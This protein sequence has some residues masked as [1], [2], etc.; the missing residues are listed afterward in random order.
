MSFNFLIRGIF[1]I[2]LTFSSLSASFVLEN[3]GFLPL[4]SVD[5]INEMAN[6]LKVKTNI[7]V[8]LIAK[9]TINNQNIKD[10]ELE[11]VKTLNKPFVLLTFAHKE[12]K[13]DIVSSKELSDK[14]DKDEILDNYIIPILISKG[15]IPSKY[16][17]G[18]FNGYTEIVDVL[19][20]EYDITLETSIDSSGRII[21]YIVKYIFWAMIIGFFIAFLFVFKRKN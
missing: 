5:K 10:Y 2:S 4:K 16:G 12:T 13:I 6:E 17:A 21:Y 14:F 19:A 18:L 8:Y 20:S 1:I 9:K 15:K 11:I 3:D 7:S